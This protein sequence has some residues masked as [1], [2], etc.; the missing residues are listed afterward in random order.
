MVR[1]TAEPRT[2]TFEFAGETLEM[3]YVGPQ[4]RIEV[5]GRIVETRRLDDALIEIYG[6]SRSLVKLMV[7]LMTWADE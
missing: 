4:W 1:L 2:Q 7:E 5:D 6:E 3:T